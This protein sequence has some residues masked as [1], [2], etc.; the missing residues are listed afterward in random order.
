MK[1]SKRVH[2]TNDFHGTETSIK[3]HPVPVTRPDR[4]P[5][6]YV[7]SKAVRRARQ[8]LCGVDG[9]HCSDSF[10]ARPMSQLGREAVY[11]GERYFISLDP[12]TTE[13]GD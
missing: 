3:L 11:Y 8:R 12:E 5:V 9:C 2:L 1:A 6:F 13:A 7:D 4:S 10:G